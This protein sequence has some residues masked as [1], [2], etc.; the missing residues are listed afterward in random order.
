[1]RFEANFVR[2]AAERFLTSRHP[3]ALMGLPGCAPCAI[4][5]AHWRSQDLRF[6]ESR[7]ILVQ[8]IED[9][10]ALVKWIA[11]GDEGAFFSLPVRLQNSLGVV[12]C[13]CGKVHSIL[14][15][16]QKD[17][18]HESHHDLF[19]Q[20]NGA[21]A[22]LSG[23]EFNLI[24]TQSVRASRRVYRV[25]RTHSRLL[26]EGRSPILPDVSSLLE[27]RFVNSRFL[28]LVIDGRPE[29]GLLSGRIEASLPGGSRVAVVPEIEREFDRQDLLVY[30]ILDRFLERAYREPLKAEEILEEGAV[31]LSEGPTP[32][33]PV[34]EIITDVLAQPGRGAKLSSNVV[35]ARIREVRERL[36]DAPVIAGEV[37]KML[38]R[39]IASPNV[40]MSLGSHSI[41][42]QAAIAEL[43]MPLLKLEAG[44]L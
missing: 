11:T 21:L 8:T 32:N 35:R 23:W 4:S 20:Y 30:D 33:Y 1:M 31:A 3:V 2:R 7:R 18:V 39:A 34:T 37:R 38:D 10:L 41:D 28:H 9:F 17:C 25:L 19:R 40:T 15:L 22:S 5:P 42:V 44:D 14:A 16:R 12:K 36:W 43:T 13:Y 6:P 27:V 26:A 24:P 29:C